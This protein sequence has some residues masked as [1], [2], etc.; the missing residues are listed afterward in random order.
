MDPDP[1]ILHTGVMDPVTQVFGDLDKT[2]SQLP[3]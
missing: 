3:V 1:W 2:L